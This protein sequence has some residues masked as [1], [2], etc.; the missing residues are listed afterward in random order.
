[1]QLINPLVGKNFMTD[2][3]KASWVFLANAGPPPFGPFP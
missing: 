3:S 2:F 1:M